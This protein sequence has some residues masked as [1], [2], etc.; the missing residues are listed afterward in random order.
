MKALVVDDASEV[1]E[2]IILCFKIRWPHGTLIA[3]GSGAQAVRVAQAVVPDVILLDLTLGDVYGMQVLK[4]IRGFSFSPVIIITANGDETAR[5]KTSEMG[6]NDYLVKPFTHVELLSSI[7]AAL[8]HNAH[9]GRI[10]EDSTAGT[11]GLVINLLDRR[12][13][14][15]RTEVNLTPMEWRILIALIYEHGRVVPNARIGQAGWGAKKVTT[16]VIR[17]YV[18]RLGEKLSDDPRQP[19]LIQLWG[20]QGYSL[21]FVP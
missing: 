19:E 17:S 7:A 10:E 15:G 13:L 6:A 16:S 3:T 21:S 18:S 4:E 5:L 1:I 20:E 11:N 12:V 8:S 2:S 9:E 14:R